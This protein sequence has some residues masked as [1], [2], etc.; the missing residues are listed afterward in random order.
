MLATTYF[1]IFY[2]FVFYLKLNIYDIENNLT[3]CFL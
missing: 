1:K 2:L 3:S